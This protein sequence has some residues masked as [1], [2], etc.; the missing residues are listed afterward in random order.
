[1]LLD[2]QVLLFKILLIVLAFKEIE[3]AKL[4]AAMAG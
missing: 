4:P 1:V 3:H 2:A